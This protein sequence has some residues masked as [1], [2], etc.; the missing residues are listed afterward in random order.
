LE[1]GDASGGEKACASGG[2]EFHYPESLASDAYI[3]TVIQ[4]RVGGSGEG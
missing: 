1:G 4:E 2:L 3:L